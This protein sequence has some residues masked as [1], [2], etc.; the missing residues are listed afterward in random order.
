M[1][2]QD[3]K[4]MG[5]AYL[6]VLEAMHK[7]KMDPVDKDEL[8]GDHKDRDDK[9][10]DNDGDADESDVYLHTRRKAI[11]KAT[12]G[13]QEIETMTSESA[14]TGWKIYQRVLEN[15]AMQT[16]GATAPMEADDGVSPIAK[17]MRKDQLDAKNVNNDDVKGAMDALSAGRVTKKAAGRS[18]DNKSGDTSVIN[19]VIDVTKR[20]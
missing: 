12:K 2:T 3:I 16:K 9:D 11:S 10:I 15:R 13:K 17:K 4:N 1:K 18:N 6:S 20:G 5:Q 7:K 19:P 14:T 8:K